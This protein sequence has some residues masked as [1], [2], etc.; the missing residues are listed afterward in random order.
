MWRMFLNFTKLS[1]NIRIKM[2]DLKKIIPTTV[3]AALTALGGAVG[4][5][6]VAAKEGVDAIISD[7][8]VSAESV[9]NTMTVLKFENG[10]ELARLKK[11]LKPLA[12]KIK[13]NE[14][15]EVLKM[16]KYYALLSLGADVNIVLEGGGNVKDLVNNYIYNQL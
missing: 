11:H 4:G 13:N 6:E 2:A 15:I 5:V 8:V 1:R 7:D 16:D 12:L 10:D 14:R 9:K 3:V